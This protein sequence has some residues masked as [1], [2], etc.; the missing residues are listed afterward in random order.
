MNFPLLD[1]KI[2]TLREDT[3]KSWFAWSMKFISVNK[4]CCFFSVNE[5]LGRT[6][7]TKILED[8]LVKYKVYSSK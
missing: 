8:L 4:A 6:R 3:R 2:N 5:K 1:I 7:R